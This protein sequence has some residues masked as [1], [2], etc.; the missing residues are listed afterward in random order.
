MTIPSD[1]GGEELRKAAAAL[2]VLLILHRQYRRDWTPS[3]TG[4]FLLDRTRD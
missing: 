1:L 3:P 2:M 4:T